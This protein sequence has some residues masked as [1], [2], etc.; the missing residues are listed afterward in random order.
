[1]DKGQPEARTERFHGRCRPSEKARMWALAQAAGY[2]NLTEYMLA[3][4]LL[5]KRPK[6]KPRPVTRSMTPGT[7]GRLDDL[8]DLLNIQARAVHRGR[9]Y[10]PSD[11]LKTIMEI[12]AVVRGDEATAPL[13]RKT[14]EIGNL[15]PL[16]APQRMALDRIGNNLQQ[17]AAG[18]PFADA[19][20]GVRQ[21]AAA[22]DRALTIEADRHAAMR[23]GGG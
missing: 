21:F 3:C 7:V 11:I 9:D 4:T 15:P 5:G 19:A 16:S 22:W 8:G 23:A 20:E 18:V 1:M 12:A 2:D 6:P 14:G 17:I 10:Q 13:F